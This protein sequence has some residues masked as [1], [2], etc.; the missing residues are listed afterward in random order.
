[1]EK[2]LI[3]K[4]RLKEISKINNF[5]IYDIDDLFKKAIR[6]EIENKFKVYISDTNLKQDIEKP[7]KENVKIN[8]DRLKETFKTIDEFKKCRAVAYLK[9]YFHMRIWENEPKTN[10]TLKG[11]QILRIKT[12][13]LYN[14]FYSV[15]DSIYNLYEFII[16][17]RCLENRAEI[18]K[19]IED[20][21]LKE[22]AYKHSGVLKIKDIEF[23]LFLNGRM[24]ITFKN[25][26]ITKKFY[27][28][29]LRLEKK[30]K[31]QNNFK[32]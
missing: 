16:N 20:N 2:N 25:D 9:N 17:K 5:D 28:E 10:T 7:L 30:L 26:E 31:H 22:L 8:I 15:V 24:D 13:N 3:A 32:F 21:N 23:K 11:N 14:G 29:F 12:Y 1:M 4:Q 18:I 27:N 19:Y 6:K